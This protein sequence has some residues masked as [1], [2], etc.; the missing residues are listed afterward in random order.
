M[1]LSGWLMSMI[2][3]ILAGSASTPFL[4]N[5]LNLTP[6]QNAFLLVQVH[7]MLLEPFQY[8]R[9]VLIMFLLSFSINN[10]SP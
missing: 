4:L 2:A 3:L 6:Q 7:A 1:T 10:R 9:E 8:A 5:E